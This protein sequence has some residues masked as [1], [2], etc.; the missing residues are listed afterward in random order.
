MQR[1]RQLRT[2]LRQSLWFMPTLAVVGAVA[3]ALILIRTS[4][5]DTGMFSRLLFGGG[6][7]GARSVLQVIAGST[8]TVVSVTF[9]LTVVAL[10]NASN[11]YSPRV[12]ATFLRDRA[13]QIVLSTFLATFAYSII[14]LRTIFTSSSD[15]I[16]VP[17]LAVTVAVLLSF[18]SLA[19]LVYFIHHITQSIRIESILSS[20]QQN[21]MS[22]IPHLQPSEA[23]SVFLFDEVPAAPLTL[24]AATSGYIQSYRPEKLLR[25]AEKHGVTIRYRHVTGTYIT[26]G[27]TLAWAWDDDGRGLDRAALQK[28]ANAGADIG[29]ERT[30]D[31]DV[32]F[33]V[34]Q[35]ADIALR[36]LSTGVNDPSTAADALGQLSVVLAKLTERKLGPWAFCD[37]AGGR[38]VLVPSHDMAGY[39]E[40]VAPQMLIYGCEDPIAMQALVR[41]LEDVGQNSDDP[42]VRVVVREYLRATSEV[43]TERM[44]GAAARSVVAR[45]ITAAYDTLDRA[46]TAA[47]AP[48]SRA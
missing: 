28:A 37:S 6:V 12:L 17:R 25:L 26:E 38:R 3:A 32:A 35:L 23:V 15:D 40:I 36:A 34:R 24:T 2:E 33:G 14:V 48:H 4:T 43:T 7:A 1:L 5:P 41:L 19:A 44:I 47:P 39:L 46:P 42:Q 13:Q 11:Q 45:S 18:A 16:G 27:A 20:V 30:L 9:S 31:Q 29:S 8:M 22:A 21:T 10:V